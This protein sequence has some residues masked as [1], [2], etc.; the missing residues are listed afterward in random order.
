MAF[1][2]CDAM[3]RDVAQVSNILDKSHAAVGHEALRLFLQTVLGA[4]RGRPYKYKAPKVT[5]RPGRPR[6]RANA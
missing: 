4:R 6:R 5:K 2:M 1:G 3:A